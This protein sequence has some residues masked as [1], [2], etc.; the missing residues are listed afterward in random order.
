MKH[1]M[2]QMKVLTE[3]HETENLDI[4]YAILLIKF[5][6]KFLKEINEDE[7]QINNII[8]NAE[9]FA[10]NLDVDSNADFNRFHRQRN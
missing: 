10:K 1:I 6:I 9:I 4:I 5:C 8:S 3:Q 7:S 2:Y